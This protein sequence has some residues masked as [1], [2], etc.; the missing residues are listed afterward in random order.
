MGSVRFS[1]DV[2]VHIATFAERGGSNK[3]FLGDYDSMGYGRE[4]AT[5]WEGDELVLSSFFGNINISYTDEELSD[6]ESIKS[7]W[8]QCFG[9]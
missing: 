9:S 4:E 8:T 7:P 6:E 5:A 1:P 3:Y 2:E